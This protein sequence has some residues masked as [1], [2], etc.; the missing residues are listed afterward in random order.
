MLLLEKMKGGGRKKKPIPP[1]AR[2][3]LQDR[4]SAAGFSIAARAGP[5]PIGRAEPGQ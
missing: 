1:V 5:D 4:L 3:A 2:D